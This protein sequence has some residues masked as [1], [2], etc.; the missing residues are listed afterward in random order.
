MVEA[1]WFLQFGRVPATHEQ[2]TLLDKVYMY[3]KAIINL[4][5]TRN[6]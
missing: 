6:V 2:C 4:E 1:K 5:L 3:V